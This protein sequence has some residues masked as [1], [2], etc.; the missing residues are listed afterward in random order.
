L[1]DA[2]PPSAKAAR[3]TEARTIGIRTTPRSSRNA[4]QLAKVAGGS[5]NLIGV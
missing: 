5:A 2:Q 3:I 4:A 1:D